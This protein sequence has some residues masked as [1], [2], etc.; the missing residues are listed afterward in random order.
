MLP[1]LDGD[2]QHQQDRCAREEADDQPARPALV[3]SAQQR[4]DE[5]EERAREGDEAAEVEVLGVRIDDVRHSHGADREHGGADRQVDEEDPAPVEPVGER[6]A[7]HGADGDGTADRGAPERDRGAARVPGEVLGDQGERRREH[8]RAAE[9]L[10]GA[11]EIEL[12]AAARDPAEERRE[13]EHGDARDEHAFAAEAI[14]ERSVGEKQRRE[15]ECVRVEHPLEL[16]EAGVQVIVDARQ[17]DLHDRDVDEQHE[18]RA[19]DGHEGPPVVLR[20]LRLAHC[21][22]GD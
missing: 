11:R 9:P 14:R 15:R 1:Q 3:V 6:A 19:A 10:K 13:R 5:Q 8:G 4:E 7:E 22:A 16:R 21:R 12:E 2:E 18:R 17:R 20:P